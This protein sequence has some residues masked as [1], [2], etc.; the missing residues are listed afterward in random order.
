MN[1]K[2]K[3]DEDAND[4]DTLMS[5][6]P[7]NSPSLSTGSLPQAR[8]IAKRVRTN[9]TSRHL[10][11]PRLLE[12]L[13]P[14]ELRQVLKTMCDRHP[15]LS[16]EVASIAPRPS[17]DDVLSVLNQYETAF[18][19]SFPFGGREGSDYAFNRTQTSLVQFL[20]ALNDYTPNFLP[21]NET[22]TSISLN[23]LDSVTNMIHRIPDWDTPRNNRHKHEAYDEI[24]KAWANVIREAAKR[25]GGIQLQIGQWDQKML[26]H[27]QVSGNRLGDAIAALTSSL[28]WMP[29]GAAAADPG[30]S[31]ND[32][33]SIRQQ[34]LN[35]TYGVRVGGGPW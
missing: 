24:A 3:S 2:R 12:T 6:S 31:Q 10:G 7:S 35:G 21:P 9:A 19:L 27:H 32:P 17:V 5:R 13:S 18:R 14:D 4:G 33:N 20:D 1:R 28:N 25:G 8:R 34:L 29:Q 16:I 30:P 22:Q 26:K 15:Q 23:F 11:L